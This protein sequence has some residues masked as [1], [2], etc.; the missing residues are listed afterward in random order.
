MNQK[1][2][3]KILDLL[4][5]QY[6]HPHIALHFHKPLEL[7]VA[8]IL[9]AQSTDAQINKTTPALF[10]KYKT[11]KD[12][13]EADVEE[14]QKEI[15]SS[16]FYKSKAKNIIAAAKRIV[17]DFGGEVPDTM[18]ELTRLP[19]VA[20]KTANIVLANAFGKVV[21]I[22]VDTHVARL[23]QRLGFSKNK[24]PNKIEQ[25]LLELIPKERWYEINHLLIG[26]G[27]AVCNA[28]KPKCP[29][30]VLR[31]L[32]PSAPHFLEEHYS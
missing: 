3:L 27:R 9:S 14:F 6:S 31:E 18:D 29:S 7:L 30:C 28:K 4:E 32:C 23:S 21:G 17:S 22:A 24:D 25:D 26:H 10:K 8:T 15:Y 19:G 1:E 11:A 5:K 13:A 12:Y 2:A 20:R 16:G